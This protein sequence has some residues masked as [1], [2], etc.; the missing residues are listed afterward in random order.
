MRPVSEH[1]LWR[2]LARRQRYDGLG[3]AAAEMDVLG[4][5]GDGHLQFLRRER[6]VNQQT[7]TA[8]VGLSRAIVL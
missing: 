3:L 6:G 1:E 2:V 7:V 8:G 5:A 4:V